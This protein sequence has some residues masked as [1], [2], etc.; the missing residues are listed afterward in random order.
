ML[1]IL[2]LWL[3]VDRKRWRK[4]GSITLGLRPPSRSPNRAAWL[5]PRSAL[6]RAWATDRLLTLVGRSTEGG[7]LRAPHFVGLHALQVMPL[8]GWLVSRPRFDRL[9][10]GGRVAV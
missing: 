7:D 4:V 5:D 8:V 2:A 6:A 10:R 1:G 9:G 3:A